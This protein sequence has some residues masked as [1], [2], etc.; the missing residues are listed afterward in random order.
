MLENR[1]A[2]GL[3]QDDITIH[4]AI[5]DDNDVDRLRLRRMIG[6]LDADV[7]I[8]E[9]ASIDEFEGLIEA[10]PIDI[11]LVDHELGIASGLDAV[12]MVRK[13]A[14]NA[15]TPVVMISGHDD[16]STIVNS[17]RSGCMNFIP[18]GDL[19][20][21]RLRSTILEALTD[22]LPDETAM[23]S[24]RNATDAV[25]RGLSTGM[26]S[27][28]QPRLRRIYRQTDFIRTCHAR[29]LMPS[30][31]AVDEIEDQ[32]LKIWRFFDEVERY[33]ESLIRPLH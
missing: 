24:L 20:V 7:E 5:L 33:G 8:S 9:C 28:L 25:I 22:A 32:C 1:N 3:G 11:C 14:M 18:K 29:G 10:K 6:K 26:I 16:A 2:H 27:E 31:E 23:Q 13:N 12:A 21:D 4:I 15:N 19:S 30:P 17:V